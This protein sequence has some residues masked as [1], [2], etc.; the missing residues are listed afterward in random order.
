MKQK[1]KILF[2]S[3]ASKE[4][5]AVAIRLIWSSGNSQISI[6]KSASKNLNREGPFP[7]SN[8]KQ[9]TGN[10]GVFHTARELSR[11]G[12]NIMLTVRNAKGAD[13]FAISADE[14]IMHPIQVKAHAKKPQDTPLGLRPESYITPWW[15]FVAFALTPEPVCYVISLEEIRERMGRDP[16]TRSGKLESDRLFWL[17]RRYYTP[18][19]EAELIE[20]RNAWHRLGE[21]R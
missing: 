21:P 17:H 15:V 6:R 7:L 19:S 4:G 14:R 1:T 12:W 13:L 5:Y 3:P 2:Q 11:A 18:G 10:V 16:G 9:I 8:D 20:A